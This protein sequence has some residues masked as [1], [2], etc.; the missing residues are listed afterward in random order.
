MRRYENDCVGCPPD[1]GCLGRACPYANVPYDYCDICGSD[2]A[3]YRIN[4]EDYCEECVKAYLQDAFDELTILEK[5]EA[6]DI[7]VR[8]IPD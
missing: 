3:K 2:D 5:A 1:M 8:E 7:D 4:D 6:L